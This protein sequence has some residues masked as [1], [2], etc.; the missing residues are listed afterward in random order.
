MRMYNKGDNE[1]SLN[2]SIIPQPN[3]KNLSKS[4]TYNDISQGFGSPKRKDLFG[5][6]NLNITELVFMNTP[7]DTAT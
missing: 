4:I 5:T 2:G 7:G 3:C 6:S 1:S